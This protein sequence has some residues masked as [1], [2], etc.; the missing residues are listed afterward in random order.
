MSVVLDASVALAWC[1][2]DETS[3]YAARIIERVGGAGAH[4]PAIWPMEVGNAVLVA[5]RRK[6]ATPAETV[7]VLGLLRNL[8][9]EVEPVAVD[10][11]F[12]VVLTLAR[13]HGLSVYDATYIE[14]ALRR[15]LP[16]ATVD[17]RLGD[18]AARVGLKC[19]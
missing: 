10:D 7:E 8:P 4:V 15:A 14:L 16:L 11:V 12:G 5:E 13:A 9:I 19:A 6:R 18:V 2:K 3:E 1:F 17:R